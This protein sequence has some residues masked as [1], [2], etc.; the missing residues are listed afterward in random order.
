MT[1]KEIAERILEQGN[2]DGIRCMNDDGSFCPFFNRIDGCEYYGI[3]EN[4][5]DYLKELEETK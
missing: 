2:C 3:E 5:K 1:H 4:V